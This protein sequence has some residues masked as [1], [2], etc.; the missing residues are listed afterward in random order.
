MLNTSKL[1][2]A[3][4]PNTGKNLVVELD[5]NQIIKFNL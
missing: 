1:F 3:I 2:Q 5:F 4:L